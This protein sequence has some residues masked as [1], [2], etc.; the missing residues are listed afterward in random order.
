MQKV[1]TKLE[2]KT[3]EQIKESEKSIYQ[4]LQEAVLEK[5]E[6]D[7]KKKELK[8]FENLLDLQTAELQKNFLKAIEVHITER[9]TVEKKFDEMIER[10]ED[11]RGTMNDILREIRGK[12]K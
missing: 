6:N 10:H 8:S 5:L 1:H 11:A 2:E 7:R 12:L 9:K 3:V 4:F